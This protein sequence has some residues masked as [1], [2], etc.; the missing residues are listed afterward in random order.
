MR[1]YSSYSKCFYF[2][3]VIVVIEFRGHADMHSSQPT[4]FLVSI[5]ARFSLTIMASCLQVR[6]HFPQ[7]MHDV[8]QTFIAKAP[9]SLFM[10][11][12][13]TNLLL[14]LSVNSNSDRGHA[15]THLPHPTHLFVLT[16]GIPVCWFM[17]SASYG[18]TSMQSPQPK[19]PYM[20]SVSPENNVA[21]IAHFLT[22]T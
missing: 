21:S 4:H 16:T 8:L 5:C 9:L 10:Q 14:R 2:H 13:Y 17:L 11:P 7:P 15:L 6:T 19:H 12:T 20:H 18:Q 1:I 3:R 22:P